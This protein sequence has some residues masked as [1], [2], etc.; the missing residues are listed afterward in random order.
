MLLYLFIEYLSAPKMSL[1]LNLL[2]SAIPVVGRCSLK[3]DLKITKSEVL[4]QIY[5]YNNSDEF[6]L[7]CH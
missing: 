7:T 2:N 3:A 4:K 5:N 6:H 1:A